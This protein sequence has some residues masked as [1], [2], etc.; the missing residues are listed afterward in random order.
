[1]YASRSYLQ[2]EIIEEVADLHLIPRKPHVCDVEG[3]REGG[4][5]IPHGR[6]DA[7]K[8]SLAQVMG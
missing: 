3:Q 1:M 8:G 7:V 2:I 5:R 4:N 6:E